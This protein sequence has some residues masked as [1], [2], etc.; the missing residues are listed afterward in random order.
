MLR[1]ELEPELNH[2]VVVEEQ[3][4]Y[5]EVVE[6]WRLASLAWEPLEEQVLERRQWVVVLE[7]E[8]LLV[9]ALVVVVLVVWHQHW[10]ICR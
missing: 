4:T 9:V 10:R 1:E 3:K 8:V 2:P 6:T 5:E 7:A